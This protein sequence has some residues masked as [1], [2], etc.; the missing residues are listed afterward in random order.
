MAHHVDLARLRQLVAHRYSQRAMAKGARGR[1]HHAPALA[2]HTAD[3][4]ARTTDL[5]TPADPPAPPTSGDGPA[6]AGDHRWGSPS[7]PAGHE[8][9]VRALERA[10][11]PLH[12]AARPH[13][14][15]GAEGA[16][17]SAGAGSAPELAR[18]PVSTSAGVRRLRRW[19]G[20]QACRAPQRQTW[21]RDVPGLITASPAS[22]SPTRAFLP[23]AESC[24]LDGV[25]SRTGDAR[26]AC[27]VRKCLDAERRRAL[28]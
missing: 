13:T 26:G 7:R 14:S 20:L 4:G 6:S 11:A 9:S 25:C 21:R 27:P 10:R 22:P 12:G 18:G 5:S 3:A 8:R 2:P 17:Q 16:T 15:H 19:P 23:A 1:A 24:A 28:D